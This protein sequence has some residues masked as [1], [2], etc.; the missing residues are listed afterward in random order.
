MAEQRRDPVNET[1][2]E[3]RALARR[4]VAEASYGALAVQDPEG[5]A[6][7]VSRVA[8][9]AMG[10]LPVLLV[11]DLSVHTRALA[12]NPA[13]SILLGEPGPK[14]DP[15]THPRLTWVGWAEPVEKAAHREAWLARHPKAQLYIDFSDFRMLRLAPVLGLL[16]GGFGKAYRLAS[17]DLV[18]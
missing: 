17:G 11:S 12:V 13:C 6:P 15:L 4:L 16:N 7:L 18:S 8:V 2:D 9:A 14:G 5:G 10:G 1:D 3:A